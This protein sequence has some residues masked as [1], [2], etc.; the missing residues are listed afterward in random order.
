M[1]IALMKMNKGNLF[2]SHVAISV[3]MVTDY[4]ITIICKNRTKFYVACNMN[5]LN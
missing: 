4:D 3:D 1:V 2:P 5:V